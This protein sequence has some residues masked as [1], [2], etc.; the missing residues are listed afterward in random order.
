[1]NLQQNQQNINI[2]VPVI[3]K[4]VYVEKYRTVYV[5]KPRVA[6]KLNA[7]VQLLGYLWVYPEDLGNFS[8][9]PVSV[10]AHLN[11]QNPH[12]RNNWRIPTP[13]EL[14][15][16]EANAEQIGLGDDIYLATDHRNGVLRL[17]STGGSTEDNASAEKNGEIVVID[18]TA[19][20]TRNVG[21]M[22]STQKG[23]EYDYDDIESYT[24]PTGWRL[25][26]VLEMKLIRQ[27]LSNID[28]YNALSTGEI[29]TSPDVVKRILF[30]LKDSRNYYGFHGWYAHYWVTDSDGHRRIIRFCSGDYNCFETDDY[31]RRIDKRDL[32]FQ[33]T[34]KAFIRLVKE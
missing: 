34:D 24:P 2:N 32:S 9:V 22:N 16:L 15:V 19:W 13:D 26:T 12:G 30:P 5:E 21:A 33:Q 18:G 4:K 11:A 10:I 23:Y 8:F 31:G 27:K 17:V 7:P 1:M 6:R 25:P 3:E 29:K 20:A 14:T 28:Y